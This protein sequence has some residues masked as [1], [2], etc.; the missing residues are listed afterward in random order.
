MRSVLKNYRAA[1]DAG[2]DPALIA[3]WIKETTAVRSATQAMIGAQRPKPARM[4]E[5][6]I[7]KIVDGLGG[8]LG[9]LHEADPRDRAEVYARIGLRL[10]YQPGTE[11]M[12]AEVTS[13]AIDG[14]DDVCPRPDTKKW[15]THCLGYDDSTR[16]LSRC[17]VGV[18]GRMNDSNEK[19]A[20]PA[21][22]A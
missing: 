1:L 16:Y 11:T 19:R 6:Q 4:T 17:R 13:P 15:P 18:N 8:L 20:I 12:I 5:D 22:R 3:G 7:G 2:G 9:L 14:V 21:S 10:T